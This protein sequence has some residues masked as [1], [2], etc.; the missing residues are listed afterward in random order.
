MN[1]FI[2]FILL[3]VS[4]C[5]NQQIN[6][7]TT[8]QS[9][10]KLQET[11]NI[12]EFKDKLKDPNYEGYKLDDQT[13]VQQFGDDETGYI[14]KVIPEAGYFILF[15]EYY[16]SG[17][18]KMKGKTYKYGNFQKGEWIECN[19]KGE[20][21]KQT[22]Y[23]EPFTYGFD[24]IKSYCEANDIDL[25]DNGTTLNRAFEADKPIWY[26]SYNTRELELDAYIIKNL[27]ISGSDGSIKELP[28]SS[29]MDN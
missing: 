18:L 4:N 8:I 3:L 25:K 23:D 9:N 19:S 10:S 20:V 11:F 5:N 16:P 13:F 7:S 28:P 15:K 24:E 26:L 29:W 14:E 17:T 12:A 27:E 1:Q 22:N 6:N 21:V 2:F